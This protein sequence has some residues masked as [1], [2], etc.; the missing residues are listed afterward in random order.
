MKEFHSGHMSDS[1]VETP[2]LEFTP[3]AVL[4]NLIVTALSSKESLKSAPSMLAPSNWALIKLAFVKSTEGVS[5]NV[6]TVGK[7]DACLII[8]NQRTCVF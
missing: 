2:V 3:D 7:N 5:I 1:A 8:R 4:H 6:L